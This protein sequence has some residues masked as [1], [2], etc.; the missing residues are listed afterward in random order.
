MEFKKPDPR[1]FDE[2]LKYFSVRPDE[3]IYVGDTLGD[4]KC[5]KEAGLQF[6]AVLENGLNTKKDFDNIPIDFFA[7]KFS[8][9]LDYVL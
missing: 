1:V 2:I 9:I 3:S 4:A 5:A 6:I 8:D 7:E